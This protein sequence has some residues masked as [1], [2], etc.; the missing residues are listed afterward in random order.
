MK[1]LPNFIAGR[2]YVPESDFSGVV[3]DSNDSREFKAG[4]EV[5]GW[6][7]FSMSTYH[8]SQFEPLLTSPGSQTPNV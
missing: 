7:L 5:F 3:V 1:L 4:D 6:I 8:L 2:P